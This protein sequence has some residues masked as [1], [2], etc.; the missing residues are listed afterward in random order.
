MPVPFKRRRRDSY[1]N[2]RKLAGCSPIVI[3]YSVSS[4]QGLA[5]GRHRA[6]VSTRSDLDFRASLLEPRVRRDGV[7]LHCIE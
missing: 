5:A 3:Y 4:D 7:H 2:N 1:C 6:G